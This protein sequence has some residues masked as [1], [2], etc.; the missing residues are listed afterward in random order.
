[1]S[2]HILLTGGTGFIGRILCC[3]LLAN[4]DQITV[5]SRQSAADVR[6]ICGRVEALPDLAKLR[7][8]KGFDAIINL[9][10][11]GIAEKRWS[12]TRKQAIRDSRIE[13]TQQLVDVVKTW[14]QPPQVMV[15]GS[16]VGFYGAHGNLEVTEAT[17][18]H[19]EFTHRLCS[20][21][22]QAAM[23]LADMGVRVCLSRTGIVV[24][25]S[26]GFLQRMV[27]PFK[28]G[29]GGKLGSGEQYM[30][31]VHRQDVVAA[32]LWMLNT[33]TAS[34]AYN[35]VSPSPVTNATFTKTMGSV[36]HRPTILPAPA[37]ALKL[38]LGEMSGLLLTGQRAIPARLVAEGF[39]FRFTDLEPA[40]K[41]AIAN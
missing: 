35:V 28:L 14:Q 8:H 3:E 11:E 24:G 27:L 15:S 5:L 39:E 29:V 34:G 2:R 10:G 4:G 36:L 22:E 26:G 18:P 7:G 9:A 37:V 13:L 17:L 31:W 41:D 38:A 6:A 1:M 12:E 23:K 19:N 21:W 40:L 32:L 20:D 25:A 16:A 30:P 33:E